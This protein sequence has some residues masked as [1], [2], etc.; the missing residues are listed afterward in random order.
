MELFE[1]GKQ[2]HINAYS[3][4]GPSPYRKFEIGSSF[5]QWFILSNETST[6]IVSSVSLF[7]HQFDAL[8]HATSLP[9]SFFCC[10]S[11]CHAHFAAV[12]ALLVGRW[13]A[14]MILTVILF[15][16]KCVAAS[17]YTNRVCFS[18]NGIQTIQTISSDFLKI[19]R[20]SG[21]AH[22]VK[23]ILWS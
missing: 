11:Q 12:R 3:M 23:Y 6:P 5:L 18:E 14:A 15:W 17:S 21:I 22:L 20:A 1:Y 7:Q 2:V 8:L 9:L 10:T 19:L 13:V 4:D 16:T